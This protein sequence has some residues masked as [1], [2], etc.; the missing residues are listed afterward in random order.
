VLLQEDVR[1]LQV[2]REGEWHI[3]EPVENAFVVRVVRV[4]AFLSICLN[5]RGH[6][7]T[8]R[9]FLR[10]RHSCKFLFL[11]HPLLESLHLTSLTDQCG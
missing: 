6:C 3:V 8:L 2:W 9:R 7:I 5:L 10:V 4:R 1:A 11:L